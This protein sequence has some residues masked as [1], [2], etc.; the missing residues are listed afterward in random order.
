MARTPERSRRCSSRASDA[1]PHDAEA[2][3][4]SLGRSGP[5]WSEGLL[6]FAATSPFLRHS[7][8]NG[9]PCP[10]KPARSSP[11]QP[12]RPR[13][14]AG[15]LLLTAALVCVAGGAPQEPPTG[16]AD[17]DRRRH[18]APR[19]PGVRAPRPGRGEPGR[20]PHAHPGAAERPALRGPLPVRARQPAE[21]HPAPQPRRA[22]VR[23]LEG[24]RGQDPGGHPRRRRRGRADRRGARLLRGLRGDDAGPPLLGQARTTPGSSRTR[25]RT[26]S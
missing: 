5:D 15:A 22:P 4:H 8:S 16:R 20:V 3:R 25:P 17:R 2:K 24:H 11:F 7:E 14:T 23:G 10:S 12:L 13:S 9:M 18:P 1:S 6:R 19:G 21:R 26:T